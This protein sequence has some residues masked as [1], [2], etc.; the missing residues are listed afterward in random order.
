MAELIDQKQVSFLLD[1]K[2]LLELL[3]SLIFLVEGVLF[4]DAFVLMQKRDLII[5]SLFQQVILHLQFLE[6]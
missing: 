1:L 5:L 6:I 3:D 4:T 2:L